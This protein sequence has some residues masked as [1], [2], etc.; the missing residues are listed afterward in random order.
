M[1]DRQLAL[2]QLQFDLLCTERR[3]N[4]LQAKAADLRKGIAVL[5]APEHGRFA[6]ARIRFRS[7]VGQRH[8]TALPDCG[9]ELEW[10]GERDNRVG[11]VW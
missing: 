7:W 11:V 5:T 6:R 10:L 1:S 4:D 9:G 2:T 8:A 3:I